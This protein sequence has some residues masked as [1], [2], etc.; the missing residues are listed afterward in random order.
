V[1]QCPQGRAQASDGWIIYQPHDWLA[2]T[3]RQGSGV[4]RICPALSG[5]RVMG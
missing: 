2:G 3:V 1:R 4:F 5:M